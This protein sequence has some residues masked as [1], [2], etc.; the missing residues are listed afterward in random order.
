M[1]NE[2]I[3][4]TLREVAGLFGIYHVTTFRG[5]RNNSKGTTQ[6][7]TIDILDSEGQYTCIVTSD[8][9]KKTTGNPGSPLDL[10][11]RTVHWADLDK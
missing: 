9:G 3:M 1:N 11:L 4:N 10:V 6:E 8:D 7:L 5:L 2:E